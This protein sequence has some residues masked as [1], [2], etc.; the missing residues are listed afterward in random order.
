MKFGCLEIVIFGGNGGLQC[1]SNEPFE[2][3]WGVYVLNSTSEKCNYSL[4]KCSV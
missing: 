2:I 3:E 1:H 4:L